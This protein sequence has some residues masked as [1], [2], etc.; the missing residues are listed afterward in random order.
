M[1]GSAGGMV[2]AYGI[3]I[4]AGLLATLLLANTAHAASDKAAERPNIIVV[5][6]DDHGQWALGAYGLQYIQTP[7]R[8]WLAQNGVLFKN[9]MSVAPVC[10][11]ARAVRDKFLIY[12]IPK[13]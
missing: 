5:M 11:P 4:L 1:W 12:I 10:S 13:S 6:A 9:A 7:N 3:R 2:T 8:D